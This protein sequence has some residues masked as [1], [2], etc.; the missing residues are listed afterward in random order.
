MRAGKEAAQHRQEQCPRSKDHNRC[1]AGMGS[2]PLCRWGAEAGKNAPPPRGGGG[3]ACRHDVLFSSAA[4]PIAI[5]CP[6]LGPFL[7][8]GS[9]VHPPLTTLCPSSSSLPYLSLSTSLS[10]PWSVVPTEPLDFPCFTALCQVHTEKGNCPHRW[11]GAS[12]QSI[13]VAAAP[14]ASVHPDLQPPSHW[15]C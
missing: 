2:E 9:G 7:S 4:G 6:S 10:F 12:Q 8:V 14:S 1:V 5:R 3:V 15:Q 11:P 13:C